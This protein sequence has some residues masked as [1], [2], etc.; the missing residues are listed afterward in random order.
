MNQLAAAR[1]GRV[2]LMAAGLA[3]ELT[4]LNAQPLTQLNR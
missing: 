4:A 1:A 2:Y 3:L